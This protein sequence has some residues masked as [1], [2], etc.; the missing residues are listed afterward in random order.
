[1]RLQCDIPGL[2]HN[3]IEFSD[4]WSRAER[5]QFG[6]FGDGWLALIA[7][8]TVAVHMDRPG[9]EPLTTLDNVTDEILDEVDWRVYRWFTFTPR[10]HIEG[11]D[12]LGEA[13]RRRLLSKNG[14]LSAAP[15]NDSRTPT[16]TPTS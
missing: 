2:E 9:K 10:A 16:P 1:M 6:Q 13:S 11:L 15:V 5:V 3:F 7:S 12:N 14:E 4:A 8:K